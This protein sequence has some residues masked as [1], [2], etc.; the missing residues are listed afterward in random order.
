MA[1]HPVILS[2]EKLGPSSESSAENTTPEQP[3][4]AA[5]ARQIVRYDALFNADLDIWE[6]PFGSQ[7]AGRNITS[8]VH[9]PRAPYRQ[10]CTESPPRSWQGQRGDAAVVG[11][12][13][14]AFPVVH[15][16]READ[17]E[18]ARERLPTSQREDVEHECVALLLELGRIDEPAPG[19]GA[20]PRH[21]RDVLLA[22]DFERH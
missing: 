22:I 6:S 3:R 1:I 20:R 10:I 2:G 8:A 17:R 9:A 7:G 12:G 19:A 15:D 14:L 16:H 11:R 13:V 21:D 4:L 5:I 18:V